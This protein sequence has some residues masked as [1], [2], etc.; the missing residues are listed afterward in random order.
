MLFSGRAAE[1]RLD[2]EGL[3]GWNRGALGAVKSPP[4]LEGAQQHLLVA[5]AVGGRWQTGAVQFLVLCATG[6]WQD[7]SRHGII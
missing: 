7:G 5:G 4:W 1:N 2:I 6:C 3:S